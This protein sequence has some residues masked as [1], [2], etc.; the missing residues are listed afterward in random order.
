MRI[1]GYF[2]SCAFSITVVITQHECCITDS[3]A[4]VDTVVTVVVATEVP[5]TTA[6]MH[7]V[8]IIIAFLMNLSQKMSITW[9]SSGSQCLSQSVLSSSLLSCYQS[10]LPLALCLLMLLAHHTLY[11]TIVTCNVCNM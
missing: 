7:L 9:Q 2:T 1:Y 8:V 10:L 3:W 11:N 5:W 6:H 4:V